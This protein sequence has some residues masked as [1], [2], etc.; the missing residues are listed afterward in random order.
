EN[1]LAGLVNRGLRA[2]I[3]FPHAGHLGRTR[4]QLRKVDA[5]E[6]H[7]V[8]LRAPVVEGDEQ[9][10]VDEAAAREANA[11]RPEA[12]FAISTLASGFVSRQLGLAVVSSGRLFRTRATGTDAG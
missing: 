10:A 11:D 6:L 8:P 1:E 9:S 3:T 12:W 2:V 5:H 7:K 4:Q